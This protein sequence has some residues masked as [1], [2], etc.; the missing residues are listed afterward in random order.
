MSLS[1]VILEFKKISLSLLPFF[2]LTFGSA[3]CCVM[4]LCRFIPTVS[5]F[6]V[7]LQQ[8]RILNP[9]RRAG[10]CL[11]FS[12][13][14]FRLF[15]FIRAAFIY[16]LLILSIYHNHDYIFCHSSRASSSQPSSLVRFLMTTGCYWVG[17]KKRTFSSGFKKKFVLLHSAIII[18]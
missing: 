10:V 16:L 7:S 6:F 15:A 12:S 14:S 4:F 13:H 8:L 2:P 11:R 9:G 5:P 18:F 1:T 3:F 17:Q